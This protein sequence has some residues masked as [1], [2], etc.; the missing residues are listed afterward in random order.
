MPCPARLLDSL[1]PSTAAAVCVAFVAAAVMAF[2]R[3]SL[4]SPHRTLRHAEAIRRGSM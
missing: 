3:D 2:C 4:A 1:P